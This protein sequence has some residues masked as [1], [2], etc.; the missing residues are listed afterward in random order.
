MS[1]VEIPL[2]KRW[3]AL[4][5]SEPST[6]FTT[7][8]EDKHRLFDPKKAMFH[9]HIDM[10]PANPLDLPTANSPHLHAGCPKPYVACSRQRQLP[11]TKHARCEAE[12]R[13]WSTTHKRKVGAL[14]SEPQ[15]GWDGY[16]YEWLGKN[17]PN[18]NR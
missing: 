4:G 1:V 16:V 10:S 6:V 17:G 18:K 3:L 11:T 5:F 8:C 2:L 13:K 9:G 12:G 7:S 14:H 15:V